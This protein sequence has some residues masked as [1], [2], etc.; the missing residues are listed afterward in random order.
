MVKNSFI[1]FI[2]YIVFLYSGCATFKKDNPD[3]YLTQGKSKLKEKDYLS[4]ISFLK[5]VEKK[6]TGKK[7]GPETLLLI[8]E[9]YFQQSIEYHKTIFLFTEEAKTIYFN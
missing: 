3:F 6:D 2:I 9:A 8:G 5:E 4:A 7:F 1:L